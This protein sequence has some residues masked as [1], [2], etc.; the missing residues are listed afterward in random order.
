MQN[1]T[2]KIDK[3]DK[4]IV[5]TGGSGLVGNAIQ[6]IKDQYPHYTFKFLSSK[7]YDLCK[8]DQTIQ[9]FNDCKPD[10]VIHLAAC[11]GGLFKNMNNKVDMLE[12]N[13]QINYNV[14]NNFG[15]RAAIF[16]GSC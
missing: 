7:E 9:M 12:K 5:V 13:L 15:L 3:Q 4:M 1:N 8:M 11:V 6:T 10:Y 2:L 16:N 14:V